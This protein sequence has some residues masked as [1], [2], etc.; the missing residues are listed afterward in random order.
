MATSVGEAHAPVV[1]R[2]TLKDFPE[3]HRSRLLKAMLADGVS[4]KYY[5]ELQQ[6]PCPD[7]ENYKEGGTNERSKGDQTCLN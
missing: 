4:I 3:E 6:L 2:S 5:P 1:L 7:F